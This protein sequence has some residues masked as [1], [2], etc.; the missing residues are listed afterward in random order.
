MF[1]LD[2]VRGP[3]HARA[4][5][6]LKSLRQIVG[7]ELNFLYTVPPSQRPDGG[8]ECG[9]SSREHALHACFAAWLLGAKADLRSGDY[10]VLSQS[11]PPLTSLDTGVAH[12]WCAV[13]GVTPI[14]LGMN[15]AFYPAAP[16]LKSPVMGE[17]VNG[18]WHVRYAHDESILDGK[19]EN[20]HEIIFI[21]RKVHADTPAALLNDPFLFLPPPRIG[22]RESWHAYFGPDFY[23]KISL[24]CFRCVAD[25]AI[26]VRNRF[27]RA[28]AANWIAASYPAPEKQI[29]EVLGEGSR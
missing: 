10:A 20:E 5:N 9:W 16:Q 19:I 14:D 18:G 21:E 17:G 27:T 26:S 11:L 12:A 25:P 29:L 1:A 23:A 15:F 24:H 7:P 2:L 13:D 6:A 22:D 8:V 4:M 28:Q 3:H